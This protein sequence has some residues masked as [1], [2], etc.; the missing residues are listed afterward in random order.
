MLLKVGPTPDQIRVELVNASA[1]AMTDSRVRGLSPAARE[2]S[3]VAGISTAKREAWN[4]FVQAMT[5]ETDPRQLRK[6]YNTFMTR[7][8]LTDG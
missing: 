3:N 7:E 1:E 8:G 4:T 2:L 5:K 6:L